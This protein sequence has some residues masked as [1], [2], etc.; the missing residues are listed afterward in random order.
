[1]TPRKSAHATG[2]AGE[3][4][5]MERLYRM[6]HEP[7]L[8]LGNAK[9]IDIIVRLK[10]GKLK[11]ISVKSVCGGGKWPV[12]KRDLAGDKDLI[13]VFLLYRK[14]KDVTTDPDVWV[15]RA[16]DV[17]KRKYRWFD[18]SAIYYSN[19]KHAPKD[20]ERFS[21]AWGLIR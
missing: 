20:L 6:D 4:F 14:F 11:T 21:N 9:S 15:M 2:M 1:M 7:A 10:T 12:D 3:F 16:H 8:T 19:R 13:F 5:V 18:K 17:E